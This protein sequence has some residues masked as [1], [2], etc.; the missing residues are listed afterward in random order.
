M[1]NEKKS[2]VVF[3]FLFSPS[4]SVL[5]SLPC[6]ERRLLEPASRAST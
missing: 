3:G 4:T 6:E 2:I 1:V 5:V